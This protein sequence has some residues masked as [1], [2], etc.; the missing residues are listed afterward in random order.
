MSISVCKCEIFTQLSSVKSIMKP[1]HDPNRQQSTSVPTNVTSHIVSTG[2]PALSSVKTIPVSTAR[3]VPHTSTATLTLVGSGTANIRPVTSVA[4]IATSFHVSKATVANISGPRSAVTGPMMRNI[5][6]TPTAT[7]TGPGTSTSFV[8]GIRA[9][10]RPPGV[11]TTAGPAWAT[12]GVNKGTP[13]ATK[14]TTTVPT[15]FQAGPRVATPLTVTTR[16]IA[17]TT[18]QPRPELTTLRTTKPTGPTFTAQTPLTHLA[19]APLPAGHTGQAAGTALTLQPIVVSTT[20]N[21]PGATKTIA[22]AGTPGRQTGLHPIGPKVITQPAHGHI[23]THLSGGKPGAPITG[24]TRGQVPQSQAGTPFTTAPGGTQV[25]V[26]TQAAPGTLITD[27]LAQPGATTT[28]L[29]PSG[30]T[31]LERGTVVTSASYSLPTGYYYDATAGGGSLIAAAPAHP[32]I[33]HP[34]TSHQLIRTFTPA[35]QQP[36]MHLQQTGTFQ[37]AE[38]DA[39]RKSAFASNPAVTSSN[40]TRFNPVMVMETSSRLPPTTQ[41][42]GGNEPHHHHQQQQQQQQPPTSTHSSSSGQPMQQVSSQAPTPQQQQQPATTQSQLPVSSQSCSTSSSLH[43]STPGV[44]SLPS[45]PTSTPSK[46]C[47]SPR[48]SILRKREHDGTPSKV[49]KNLGPMLAALLPSGNSSPPPSPPGRPDSRDG[50]GKEGSGAHSSAGSSTIS[51]TSSPG[52]PC[53]GDNTGSQ[54]SITIKSEPVDVADG[55]SNNGTNGNGD[56]MS[57]RKKPRKQQ[58]TGNEL[59]EP[60]YS[61]ENAEFAED[62]IK[63]EN[64]ANHKDGQDGSAA[65]TPRSSGASIASRRRPSVS[66]LQAYRTCWKPRN[67]HF[68]R[69]SDVRPRE[70]RRPTVAELSSQKRVA[71]REEDV[72]GQLSGVLDT[73]EKAGSEAGNESTGKDLNRTNELIRSNMQRSKVVRDQLE[74]CRM[75]LLRLLDHTPPVVDII[76]RNA[77]RRQAKKKY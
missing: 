40:V 75:Q 28:T 37:Q 64:E 66:L 73:M 39:P 58:L 10:A 59:Q 31:P 72:L 68:V 48:P 57:P 30:I 21:P 18:P 12:G 6:T 43:I 33:A 5:V 38:G 19:V 50:G 36:T 25:K 15:S 45:T 67:N 65:C 63:K 41:A 2:N 62:Q 26:L 29:I 13:T 46:F 1:V 23:I 71:Q 34:G 35:M 74:E 54:G 7:P 52:L 3:V 24:V 47:A 14:I 60:P 51:A 55:A 22:A 11:V 8:P 44:S 69:P 9:L 17:V 42:E 4:G 53:D 20:N 16:P 56:T 70:E 77:N 49:Q 61:D 32:G 76:K 27:V